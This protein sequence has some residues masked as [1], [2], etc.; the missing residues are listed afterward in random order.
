MP[1]NWQMGGGNNALANFGYGVQLGQNMV[2]RREAR[3]QQNALL[4]MRRKELDAR[5]VEQQQSQ[6][7]KE[8]QQRRANMGDVAKL[9]DGV[10]AE[11]YGQRVSLAQ[12]MGLDVSGVPQGYDPAWIEQ[13]RTAFQFFAD[14]PEVLSNAGKQA[15]DA[16]FEPGTPEY[17]EAVRRIVSASMARPYTGGQ[18]ETRLY[19][20]DVF[21]GGGQVQGG[22]QPG[23]IEDG[24][25][26]KGGNPADP[27]SWE[28][29]MSDQQGGQTLSAAAQGN[30]I[31][32][33]EAARVRQ[34]LG[35]N[36]QSAFEQWLRENNIVIGAR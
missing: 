30:T 20:P 34:S 27:N 7:E 35:P 17:T 14:K 8:R 28:Q 18:G 33:E 5:L 15:I 26:F 32:P 9:F 6:A 19:T 16:G 22:P 4:D 12:Q 1:V 36:G 23:A 11:N 25:R 21:G 3:E 31:T 13:Q 29:V 10:T 2:D 24:Y